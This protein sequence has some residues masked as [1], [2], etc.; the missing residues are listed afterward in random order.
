MDS[1]Q[2]A[3]YIIE[4]TGIMVIATADSTGKPWISPVGF[5]YDDNHNLYWV[6]YKKALHSENIVGRPEVAITIFGKLPSGDTDG[7]YIDATAHELR[8]DPE[9]RLAMSLFA[10]RRPQISKF[11]VNTVRD[12]TCDAVWRMYKAVPVSISK[13]ADKVI[14]GQSITVREP[15]TL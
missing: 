4:N 3:K 1:S 8:N 12:V 6:S 7:V 11:T 13:R 9:I 10:K 2:K 14:D 15:V 5:T